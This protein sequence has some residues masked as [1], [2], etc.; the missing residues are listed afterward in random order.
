MHSTTPTYTTG[1]DSPAREPSWSAFWL[2]K[3]SILRVCVGEEDARGGEAGAHS[4]VPNRPPQRLRCVKK[5]TKV[6][7]VQ[8]IVKTR[9]PRFVG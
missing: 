7:Q 1:K 5:L 9:N 4:E 8:K 2:Q 3:P 6:K